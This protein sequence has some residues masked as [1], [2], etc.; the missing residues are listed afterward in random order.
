M[1]ERAAHPAE[2]K[3]LQRLK[4]RPKE[5]HNRTGTPLEDKIVALVKALARQA[6]EADI[7]AERERENG[8][9]Q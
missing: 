7:R 9:T 2:T 5:S 4:T 3:A 1:R 6:A 8:R